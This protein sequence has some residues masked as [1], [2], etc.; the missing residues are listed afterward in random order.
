[1][2]NRI[3]TNDRYLIHL[4][5]SVLH[6]ERPKEKPENVSFNGVY[7]LAMFHKVANMAFYAIEQLDT[8][9]E[10]ELM[11]QWRE[12][13]DKAIVQDIIQ[14]K[15]KTALC[16]LF[17]KNKIRCLPLKG[18]H[19]KQLYPRPDMRMMCDIDILIDVCNAK[20]VRKLMTENGYKCENFNAGN[21]DTYHKL[22]IMNV[23]IHRQLIIKKYTKLKNHYD[24]ILDR[25]IPDEQGGYVLSLPPEEF[26]TYELVHLY[27]HFI[28]GGSGIRSIMDIYLMEQKLKC[29]LDKD[30]LDEILNKLELSSFY[31]EVCEL[32]SVWFG[33]ISESEL[34]N[35]YDEY[36]ISSGAYGT[37]EHNI[38]NGIDE[39]GKTKFFI[40]RIF[41]DYRSMTGL[42]P[43]L[44]VLPILLPLCW[45]WRLISALIKKR[46]IVF[47]QLKYIRQHK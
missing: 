18:C 47:K 13:R 46:E 17:S 31:K 34:K 45:V 11:N 5:Y 6:G 16:E 15:E 21:H 35:K 38:N 2:L 7:S 39:C 24:N 44:R 23:E 36:I 9:P 4:L 42:F 19:M 37:L 30:K 33:D 43:I 25:C 40:K 8:K 1:M 28:D 22:P 3:N 20:L 32:A 10:S 26:Y 27:K 14:R 41:V 12:T 29:S